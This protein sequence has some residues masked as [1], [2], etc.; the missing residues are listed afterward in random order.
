MTLFRG[1]FLNKATVVK[2]KTQ[3]QTTKWMFGGS[4]IETGT[5]QKELRIITGCYGIISGERFSIRDSKHK[6]IN[7]TE[8]IHRQFWTKGHGFH[9]FLQG[10]GDLCFSLP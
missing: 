1:L 4:M 7:R 3:V 9:M 2:N 8:I 5:K 10:I 6:Q